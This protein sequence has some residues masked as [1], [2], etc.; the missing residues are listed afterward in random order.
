MTT[1]PGP[2][3]PSPASFRDPSGFVFFRDGAVHRQV[4]HRYRAEYDRLMSSGLYAVLVKDRLLIPHEEADGPPAD[5]KTCY[6]LLR[7]E[8]VTTISYPY[9]W[10]FSQLKDAALATLAVQER[11]LEFGMSLKDASAYNIQFHRGRPIFIDTLSFEACPEGRPWVAYRQYCQHFLAPLALMAKR[12]IRLGRLAA[13]YIDGV[14]LD[15]AAALLPGRTRWSFA[16]GTHIHLHARSQRK[17]ADRGRKV[18]PRRFS[19]NAL[20]GILRSLAGGTR[21]LNW[22]PGGTE[23][24]EYYDATNYSGEAFEHKRA[25]VE[26]LIA[27]AEPRTAWDLGANTGV[28]SRLASGRGIPTVAF[29]I[30]PAAVEKNYRDC[31]AAGEENLLPLVLD[32]TN[33]SPGLGW[34]N[35]ERASLAERGPVD[36]VLALALIH[37]L[38]I[39]NNL[40]LDK[41][42]HRFA[43]LGRRLI[44]EFVP[45]TDSQVRRLL[46][47]REDIFPGYTRAGF[48]AAFGLHYTVDQALP[49]AGTERTLYL[50]TAR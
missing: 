45:K 44:I 16:L 11:A 35:E 27:A 50:M 4:N 23:W 24:A 22:R 40:P 25:L 2:A 49:I 42:A 38:A 12:D 39:S 21:G 34:A 29:D 30:D 20:I 13:L 15:L 41:V 47:T 48:E 9:E 17:H 36:L 14:P 18:E 8:P 5:P 33:P 26:R 37:H 28:F 7:P 19:R 31:R 6:K 32:L 43:R 10:C 1:S 3:S 46:A